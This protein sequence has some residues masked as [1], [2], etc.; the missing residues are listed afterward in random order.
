MAT[1]KPQYCSIEKENMEWRFLGFSVSGTA[2][3]FCL[4]TKFP[5][6]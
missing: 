4:F 6:A 5:V 2:K 3:T 1:D